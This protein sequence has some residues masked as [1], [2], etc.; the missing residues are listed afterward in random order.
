MQCTRLV[1]QALVSQLTHAGFMHFSMHCRQALEDNKQLYNQ[2]QD[3]K[4]SIRVFCR[5]R[6]LG[7]TG[8][9]SHSCVDVGNERELATY[10]SKGERK[11][12]KF[13][14]VFGMDSTQEAVYADTQPLIRS[15][16]DGGLCS[17]GK[18]LGW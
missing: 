8:D 16:L 14:H 17:A 7:K 2:V 3:L 18:L 4:G 5:I 12:W 15:V 6:P 1:A 13:D 9:F 11:V 10:D